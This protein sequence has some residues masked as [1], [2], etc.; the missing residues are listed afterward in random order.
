MR[1]TIIFWLTIGS[2]V[3]ADDLP[4]RTKAPRESYSNVDVIY[5][6]VTLPDGKRLRTIIAKP[7]HAKGK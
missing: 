6:S 1:F 5:D 4:R 2:L 7:R 3:A